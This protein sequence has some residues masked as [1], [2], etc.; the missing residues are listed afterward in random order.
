MI[1]FPD[2]AAS[3]WRR[4]VFATMKEMAE[5]NIG[6]DEFCASDC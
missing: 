6:L 4:I 1:I 5:H 2:N 3:Q